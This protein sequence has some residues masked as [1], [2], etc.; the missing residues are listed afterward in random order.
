MD[1]R[2]ALQGNNASG[3][4]AVVVVVVRA[5][6]NGGLRRVLC[7]LDVVV[8][9]VVV[10]GGVCVGKDYLNVGRGKTTKTLTPGEALRSAPGCTDFGLDWKILSTVGF[11]GVEP[12]IAHCLSYNFPPVYF[13]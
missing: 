7:L 13:F 6:R 8:A 5:Q 2:I 3:E 9:F 1:S 11:F 10:R 4:V 12:W